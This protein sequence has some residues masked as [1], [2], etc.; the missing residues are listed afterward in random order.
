MPSEPFASPAESLLRAP[1]VFAG[2]VVSVQP[3]DGKPK[4]LRSFKSWGL[5]LR[6][7]F[8]ISGLGSCSCLVGRGG[9]GQGTSW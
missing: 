7:K 8:R 4:D 1:I 3:A 2:K 9:L 6:V 5:G